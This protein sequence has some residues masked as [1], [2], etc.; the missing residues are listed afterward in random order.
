MTP[1]LDIFQSSFLKL[2]EGRR[3]E[4]ETAQLASDIEK[5]LERAEQIIASG[6][7]LDQISRKKLIADIE[8]LSAAIS[9]KGWEP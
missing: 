5:Q 8:K 2:I 4:G 7:S 9:K 3:F 6:E 1:E